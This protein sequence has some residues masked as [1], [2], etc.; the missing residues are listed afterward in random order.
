MFCL[1]LPW[2][3]QDNVLARRPQVPTRD[4]NPS[5]SPTTLRFADHRMLFYFS[6]PTH[7][8]QWHSKLPRRCRLHMRIS[9]KTCTLEKQEWLSDTN[10]S[11]PS[12]WKGR[13]QKTNCMMLVLLFFFL[14]LGFVRSSL[15]ML[16]LSEHA[17]FASLWSWEA[18]ALSAKCT[19]IVKQCNKLL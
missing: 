3:L 19:F 12:G 4:R 1:F 17:V 14:L 13:L 15:S 11:S 9:N 7:C 16:P 5:P 10:E 2:K 18:Q 6:C 8:H